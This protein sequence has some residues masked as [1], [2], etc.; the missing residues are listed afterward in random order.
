MGY[1]VVPKPCLNATLKE[2]RKTWEIEI[3]SLH[4]ILEIVADNGE[5]IIDHYKLDGK[6]ELGRIVI[7]DDHLE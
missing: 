1:R 4:D 6:T 5:I 2:D 7:Y 3:N